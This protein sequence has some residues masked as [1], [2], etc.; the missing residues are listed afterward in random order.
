MNVA[1][2]CPPWVVY[3]PVLSEIDDFIKNHSLKIFK[4]CLAFFLDSK[5][6]LRLFIFPC[7]PSFKVKECEWVDIATGL[8]LL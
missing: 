8:S 4:N 6:Y 1:S 7:P 5:Y 2:V 3:T